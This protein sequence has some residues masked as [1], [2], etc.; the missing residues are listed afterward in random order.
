MITTVNERGRYISTFRYISVWMMETTAR[1]TPITP[2]MEAKVM[3]GRHIWEY[4]QM[5]DAL[6]KRTF[7]L[8]LP[9][10]NS[11]APAPAYDAVLKSVLNAS[12][13]ADRIATLY[14]GFIPGF[15]ARNREYLAAT[16]PILDEPSIIIIERNVQVMERQRVD[17]AELQRELKLDSGVAAAM[18]AS[19]K[20]VATILAEEEKVPA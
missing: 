12:T 10:Q 14:D 6:G 11:M 7:E 2:Q 4:A 19:E 1:W 13:T 15:I 16:D 18:A 3:L 9:E 20:A 17:A 5:A 8:R